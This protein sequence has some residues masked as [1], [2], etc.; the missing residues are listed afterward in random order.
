MNTQKIVNQIDINSPSGYWD[1]SGTPVYEVQVDGV[2]YTV[3]PGNN[4]EQSWW[5]I[6]NQETGESDV[7]EP[8]AL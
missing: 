4:D 6:T 8:V 1:S 7:T 3:V 2:T 5:S